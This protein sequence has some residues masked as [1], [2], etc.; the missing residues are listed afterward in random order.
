MLKE[1][2]EG[3]GIDVVLPLDVPRL[4]MTK[5]KTHHL[6]GTDKTLSLSPFMTLLSAPWHSPYTWGHSP[7]IFLLF[8]SL[9]SPLESVSKIST[10]QAPNLLPQ[11]PFELFPNLASWKFHL[12]SCLG[13]EPWHQPWPSPLSPCMSI[14][15]PW[16]LPIFRVWTESA[17]WSAPLPLPSGSKAP[18]SKPRFF[19]STIS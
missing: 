4:S 12:A 18:H 8:F 10:T 7:L 14:T 2:G 6:P 3:Y 13:P 11:P 5:A 15:K 16:Q 9:S 19:F 1:T 17:Y